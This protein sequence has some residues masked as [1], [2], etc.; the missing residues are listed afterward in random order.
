MSE[1]PDF[2]DMLAEALEVLDRDLAESDYPLKN[3]PLRAAQDFVRF[4]ITKVAVGEDESEPG[5]FKDYV[6]SDWFKVIYAR[7]YAWYAH[8]YGA[9][10]DGSSDRTIAG[11]AL[12]LNTPFLMR[13]PLTTTRPGQPGKTVWIGYPASM[14]EG[15]DALDWIESGPNIASLTRSDGMKARRLAE[16]VAVALRLVNT[17]LAGIENSAERVGELRDAILPHLDRA[18]RQI[19]QARPHDLK[20]AQWDM[21]MACE[22]ALKL[23]HQ[24]RAGTFPET[25]DLHRLYDQLPQGRAPFARTLLRNIPKW[26]AMA[27]WRYGGGPSISIAQAFSRYRSTLKIVQS[28]ANTADRKFRI[29]GARFEIAKAPFLHDDPDM[30]KPHREA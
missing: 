3:R 22:L 12:V 13:V 17:G 30:F 29:G 20:H 25:H 8:R 23:L 18:A 14:E 24:Q 16:E 10:F 11:C 7:V 4:C 1:Q 6:T 2:E 28:A 27:E 26:E 5:D 15:E 19:A 21:Q 9:A